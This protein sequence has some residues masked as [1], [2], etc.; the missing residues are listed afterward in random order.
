MEGFKHVKREGT[1]YQVKQYLSL[2]HIIVIAWLLIS[3]AVIISTSYLKTGIIMLIFSLLLTIVSFMP[4]KVCFDPV[5][6]C[7]TILN[8]GLNRRKFTYDLNDFEGFELQT[9]YIGFIPLGCYL[10]GSFKNVTH[11]KRPVIS[12]SFSKKTMQEVV[13]EL[14]DLNVKP[15]ATPI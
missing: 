8:R 4:P 13:N 10:Y 11:F 5:S 1:E 7:L 12:Q 14:E 3:I 15:N 2:Q 6:K 9:M